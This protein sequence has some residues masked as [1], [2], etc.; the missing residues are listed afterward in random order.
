MKTYFEAFFVGCFL[1]FSSLCHFAALITFFFVSNKATKFKQNE[2][3][4]FDSEFK[5]GRI[6]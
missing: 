5:E 6:F 4:T 3:K 2:K 1:T